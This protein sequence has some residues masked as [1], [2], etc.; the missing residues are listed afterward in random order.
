MVI[1]R[2]PPEKHVNKGHETKTKINGDR[3][4]TTITIGAQQVKYALITIGTLC[5]GGAS[6]WGIVYIYNQLNSPE[7][8]IENLHSEHEKYLVAKNWPK[9]N[10]AM[11]KLYAAIAGH[12]KQLGITEKELL[13][14][15]CKDFNRIAEAWRRKSGD[16]LGP[17]AQHSVFVQLIKDPQYK[18]GGMKLF[19]ANMRALGQD[20]ANYTRYP[21]NLSL[22]SLP[23]GA[24]PRRFYLKARNTRNWRPNLLVDKCK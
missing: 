1:S 17:Y 14:I 9:A 3:N 19:K 7:Q 16:H 4:T 21:T 8:K 24:F 2:K 18:S 22:E 10:E 23:K 12:P 6:A 5:F 20:G 11:A 13:S 15:P